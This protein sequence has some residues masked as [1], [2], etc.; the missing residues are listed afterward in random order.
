MA[1]IEIPVLTTTVD[2]LVGWARRSAIW[3]VAFGLACCAIEMMAMAANRTYGFNIDAGE[4]AAEASL[5][6]L[7]G[8]VDELVL[9]GPQ[10]PDAVAA[11]LRVERRVD[12]RGAEAV[13]RQRVH[14]VLHERDERA[15]DEDRPRQDARRDLEGE[16]L[17]GARRHDA[18]AVA[19]RQHGAD[20]TLLPGTEVRVSEDARQDLPGGCRV[21]GCRRPRHAVFRDPAMVRSASSAPSTCRSALNS[22]SITLRT[23]PSPSIQTSDEYCEAGIFMISTACSRRKSV[24]R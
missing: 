23:T 1:D 7:R 17:A 11:R 15:H 2:K 3:P 21:R 4:K 13:P 18:D 10:P 16:R 24:R 6:T 22:L 9:A 5:E 20:D 14:L 19:P 12:D 8:R